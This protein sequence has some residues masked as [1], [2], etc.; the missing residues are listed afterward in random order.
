LASFQSFKGSLFNDFK[1]L[2]TFEKTTAVADRLQA[3]LQL[4]WNFEFFVIVSELHCE[5]RQKLEKK[6][7]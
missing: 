1:T 7:T 2:T 6:D 3:A 4:R 5:K